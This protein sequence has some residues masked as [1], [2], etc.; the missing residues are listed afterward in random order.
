MA[1]A[2]F[3]DRTAPT[4]VYTYR[5]EALLNLLLYTGLR[6]SEASALRLADVEIRERS[7]KVIVR[8]GK[9][10]YTFTSP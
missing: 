3:E 6:I 2:Q 4:V 10:R 9:G 7:G 1:E 5:D 8:A